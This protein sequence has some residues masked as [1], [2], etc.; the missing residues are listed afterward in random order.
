MREPARVKHVSTAALNHCNKSGQRVT[1]SAAADAN[2]FR[3]LRAAAVNALACFQTG[4]YQTAV[5]TCLSEPTA[6]PC[7]PPWSECRTPRHPNTTRPELC[8]NSL[9]LPIASVFIKAPSSVHRPVASPCAQAGRSRWAACG[10]TPCHAHSRCS[11]NHIPGMQPN[12]QATTA[13]PTPCTAFDSMKAQAVCMGR[14]RTL[15]DMQKQHLHTRPL[16]LKRWQGQPN[17]LVTG[18]WSH[19]PASCRPPFEVKTGAL[20]MACDASSAL[21]GLFAVVET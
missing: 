14:G 12:P 3:Q 2:P 19:G 1:R 7:H 16:P 5:H 15:T 9:L 21:P 4:A 20:C 10:K 8:E 11:H 13:Q 17:I 6:S 18:F